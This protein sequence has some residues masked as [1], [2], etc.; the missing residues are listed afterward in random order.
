VTHL[1][2]EFWYLI[3]KGKYSRTFQYHLSSN[4]SYIGDKASF[5]SSSSSVVGGGGP[6]STGVSSAVDPKPR[7]DLT[8][9][10]ARTMIFGCFGGAGA[11]AILA[12]WTSAGGGRLGISPF[13]SY[14][15]V[16]GSNPM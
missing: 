5:S 3:V 14:N 8:P 15:R 13:S 12:E 6:L 7:N 11:F 10:Q 4:W 1:F 2:F 9:R 16:L